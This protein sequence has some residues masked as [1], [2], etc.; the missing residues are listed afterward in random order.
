MPPQQQRDLWEQT[1]SRK[2]QKPQD[3]AYSRKARRSQAQELKELAQEE[4][5][6]QAWVRTPLP[7]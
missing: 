6:T 1:Y 5:G 4:S 3:Q 2:A 7:S